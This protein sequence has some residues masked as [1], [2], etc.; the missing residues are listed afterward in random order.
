[1]SPNSQKD[2]Q[3]GAIVGKL[4]RGSKKETAMK[5]ITK[6]LPLAATALA[7][8]TI[9][10][11]AADHSVSITGFKFVPASLN[12]AVGD[13]VTFT[14]NDGAPHTATG[15]GFNTGTLRK[16]QSKAVTISSAGT[17]AYKCNFHP[18]M[19]GTIVAQ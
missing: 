11:F 13:T 15:S 14:N 1:M 10:A 5:N 17:F 7:F 16:G 6:I 3:A 18:S 9:G 8:A 4:S 12:V 19:T 2:C